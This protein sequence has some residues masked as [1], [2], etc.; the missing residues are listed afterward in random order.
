MCDQATLDVISEVVDERTNNKEM[1]TAYDI[2]KSVQDVFS[3]QNDLDLKNRH[4][5][6]LIKNDVHRA[7]SQVV[8]SD[9]Y[10]KVL[11]DVGASVQAFVYYPVGSDPSQYQAQQRPA[12]PPQPAQSGTTP[13]VPPTPTVA[14][15]GKDDTKDDSG[16]APDNR[17]TLAV[18]VH[19]LAAVGFTPLETAYAT[20]T[21]RSGKNALALSQ[22]PIPGESPATTYTVD[23][24]GNVR[25][26]QAVLAKAGIGTSGVSYDFETENDVAYVLEH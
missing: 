14:D 26:T 10:R 3:G 18:P 13:Y 17:G 25:V 16:R 12:A 24:Y 5:H 9:D 8:S 20:P 23:S 2:S 22:R 7:L 4:R 21:K 1:F 11:T 19:I 15:N 6:S